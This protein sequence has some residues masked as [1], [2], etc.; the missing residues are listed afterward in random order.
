M[1]TAALIVQGWSSQVGVPPLE[2][3]LVLRP[4]AALGHCVEFQ[5]MGT[6]LQ[7]GDGLPIPGAQMDFRGEKGLLSPCFASALL[8]V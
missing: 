7:K 2:S 3:L 4:F 8:A 6:S 1:V 5:K